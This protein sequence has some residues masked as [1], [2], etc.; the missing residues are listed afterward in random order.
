[1]AL[2]L[3]GVVFS[4]FEIPESIPFGGDQRLAVH[5]L[6]G[7]ARVIDSLGP[8]D[9]DIRWSGRFRGPGS[10][11]RGMLL[12]YMRRQGRKVLLAWGLHRYQVVVRQFEANYQN[13]FEIPYSIT[14]TVVL[15]ES[16]AVARAAAGL[17]EALVSDLAAATGL[18]ALVGQEAVTAAVNG[19]GQAISNYQAGVP[20]STSAATAASAV[21]GTALLGGVLTA[22]A[23]AKATVDGAI[24]ATAVDTALPAGGAPPAAIAANLTGQ[25]S[26]FGSLNNLHRLSGTLGRMAVNTTNT[27]GDP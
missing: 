8:D 27:G 24:S 14:C 2:S 20:S 6:P 23:G 22:V 4:G 26:A 13:P 1:M 21:A 7:G 16:Q 15:D 19:V 3:G 11:P 5:K 18:T 17:A 9:A 10:E 25:A 12:D